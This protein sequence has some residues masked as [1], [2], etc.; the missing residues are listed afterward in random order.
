MANLKFVDEDYESE[1]DAYDYKM[2]EFPADIPLSA[3]GGKKMMSVPFEDFLRWSRMEVKDVNIK[4]FKNEDGKPS[5]EFDYL[6]PNKN[7]YQVYLPDDWWCIDIDVWCHHYPSFVK[8]LP[9][10]I[11]SSQKRHYYC[12]IKTNLFELLGTKQAV[13]V[14]DFEL[15]PEEKAY[16]KCERG[17]GDILKKV[18]EAKDAILY[19]PEGM[20]DF[21]NAFF[22]YH[23]NRLMPYL[24]IPQTELKKEALNY[25]D[26][27]SASSD[28]NVEAPYSKLLS[29]L[30]SD[31]YEPYDNWNKVMWCL[32]F[33]DEYK[34]LFHEWSKQSRTKYSEEEVN[35]KWEYCRDRNPF[36][37]QTLLK[38]CRIEN[39]E[40]T[41]KLQEEF[42][43]NKRSEEFKLVNE[44][45]H[46][47]CAK[48]FHH[49]H[50]FN[51]LYNR[52]WYELNNY[53]VWVE[54]DEKKPYQ[55]RDE[56][57][58]YINNKLI[59]YNVEVAK[60]K[61]LNEDARKKLH[62]LICNA[63]K[64]LGNKNHKDSII[65]ELEGKYLDRKLPEKLN[66]NRNLFAFND[67][68]VDLTTGIRRRIEPSDYIS[69]TCGYDYP[70]E[71]NEDV[72]KKAFSY[73]NTM[74]SGVIDTLFALRCMAS[75]LRGI[76]YFEKLF[77]FKG[78]GGN[79]KGCFFDAMAKAFGKYW[80]VVPI[81]YWYD[82]TKKD[83]KQADITAINARY[84]RVLYSVEAEEAEEGDKNA[85]KLAVGKVKLWTGKDTIK[86]RDNFAKA[87][88]EIEYVP[89]G[90]LL[91]NTN[92]V[93]TIPVKD[94]Q[95]SDALK[96]R[97]CVSCFPYTFVEKQEDIPENST[98]HKVGN[99]Q[100]KEEMKSKEIRDALIHIL[101]ETFHTEINGKSC[102]EMSEMAK[103]T[104]KEFLESEN[105]S[106]K[107]FMEQTYDK[108][109]GEKINR[110]NIWLEYQRSD[111]FMSKV[112]NSDF[113]RILDKLGYVKAT[114]RGVNMIKNIKKKPNEEERGFPPL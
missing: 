78:K 38:F 56:M 90:A 70:N 4:R 91:W 92:E 39:P 100:V 11:S 45:T 99:P 32:P 24:K 57:F 67:C 95:G 85:P 105:I 68:V 77:I 87:K 31:W 13:G 72:K 49:S 104:T 36:G 54:V 34:S 18:F 59:E 42:R 52:G 110:T 19:F 61:N 2:R 14:L 96:R 35:S 7:S 107:T 53:G 48:Y 108:V 5:K 26:K 113:Y 6:S 60:D 37:F 47:N 80:G 103:E 112:K 41:S 1:S 55:L 98:I 33:D 102:L 89:F 109:D 9:F 10:T 20:K 64:I 58:E 84:K 51:Y 81:E 86:A 114:V 30:K 66:A 62:T 101:L 93:P 25:D 79:G 88:A 15:S 8:C 111:V 73:L 43:K 71:V 27:S 69:I 16:N 65:E 46:T 22:N 12:R 44:F 63:K 50:Q 3:D 83:A 106:V 94:K 40:A 97:L 76:N 74:F 28:E 82:T 29:L 75:C 17:Y 21:Q 23:I